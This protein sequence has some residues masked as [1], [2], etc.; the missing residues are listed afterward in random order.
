MAVA[1][2]TRGKK[3]AHRP[4]RNASSMIKG[5]PRT[6]PRPCATVYRGMAERIHWF[7][8]RSEIFGILTPTKVRCKMCNRNLKLEC[9][10]KTVQENTKGGYYHH[11]ANKHL[12]TKRHQRK[13]EVWK[14][15]KRSE[16]AVLRL[17]VI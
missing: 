1:S 6:A 11:N 9:P 10:K 7:T 5:T 13:M 14:A 8:A 4:N 3:A 12:K 15:K 16:L 2:N 17:R